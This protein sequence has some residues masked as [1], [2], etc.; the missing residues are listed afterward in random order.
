MSGTSP[1][2][3]TATEGSTTAASTGPSPLTVGKH[4]VKQYYQV[5]Q[6]TPDQIFRFYQPNSF[7]SHAEGSSPTDPCCLGG[8]TGGDASTYQIAE[9]WGIIAGTNKGF[10]MEIGAIDAQ[11][12]IDNSILLVVTGSV[13]DGKKKGATPLTKTFVHTFFLTVVPNTKRYYVVNDV[14][15]FLAGEPIVEEVAVPEPEPKSVSPVPEP[16]ETV[17]SETIVEK[18]VVTPDVVVSEV[19]VSVAVVEEPI[20]DEAPGGGVEETKEELPEE[21]EVAPA[22][23][24][25]EPTPMEPAVVEESPAA[26]VADTKESNAPKEP[27][28]AKGNTGGRGKRGKGKASQPPKQQQQPQ[29][30]QQPPASKAPPGSWA[31]LVASGP[32]PAVAPSPSKPAPAPAP[33]AK[34]PEATPS[35][36]KTP[37]AT[38]TA[39][40]KE[41]KNGNAAGGGGK[42]RQHRNERPKRDPD[43]TIV[44]KNLPENAKDSDLVALFE[45][46][47]ASGKG[48]IVGTTVSAHKGLG[49]VDYDSVAPV[50]AAMEAHAAKPFEL[51]GQV[52]VVDQKTAEQRA[53]RNTRGSGGGGGVQNGTTGNGGATYKGGAPAGSSGG[54][55]SG[56]G[57]RSNQYRRGGGGGGRGGERG[58]GGGGGSGRGGRSGR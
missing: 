32:S 56:G 47:A 14:L 20:I 25:P 19:E 54:A 40:D 53:R 34:E 55:N 12:S 33:S 15:R 17:Q 52:L 13:S 22:M 29:Q 7:L 8:A 49:F 30:Q 26:A 16:M 48:K 36:T 58:G 6:T 11:T 4:F 3:P 9:R 37:P 38:S 42:G 57:G 18:E 21:D 1:T 39:Q 5:L 41:T 35:E 27:E 31:S 51:N 10:A 23:S 45:P 2:S 24:V 46:F 43:C 28:P 44:V 50:K